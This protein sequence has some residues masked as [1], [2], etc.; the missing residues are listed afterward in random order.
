[1]KRWKRSN[2]LG[3]EPPIE[4]LAVMLKEENNTKLQKAYL[5]E[6]SIVDW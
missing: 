3:L 1:M 5:D 6:L 2:N 4:V